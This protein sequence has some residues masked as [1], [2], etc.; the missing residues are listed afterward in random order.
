MKQVMFFAHDAG[1]ANAIAPLIPSFNNPYVFGKGPAL[2]ILPRVQEMP[3]DAIQSIEPAFLITGTSGTDFSERDLWRAAEELHIPSL[4]VLDSWVNYGIRFSDYGTDMLHLFDRNCNRLPKYISVPDSHA[5]YDMI[6]DGVP[7][8]RIYVFGNPYFEFLASLSKSVR[9]TQNDKKILFA[10]QQFEDIYYKDSEII[11]LDALVQLIE[12]Y[13]DITILI[14]KHPNEPVNK[15]EQ[16]LDKRVMI[17]NNESVFESIH[18]S[19]VVV[20]VNS[21]VLI[22]AMF[23]SKKIISYQPKSKNGKDDFILTRN[24]TLPFINNQY[25]FE[26][27]FHKVFNAKKS[28]LTR[29][30]PCE[31]ITSAIS[32]FIKE[33]IYVET[34]N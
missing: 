11:V 18:I 22:E 25:D 16:Y 33:I 7:E 8:N 5:K 3:E 21:M 10:S 15:F 30:I 2:K 26:Q 28:S 6:N 12:K 34:R 23:F 14:R 9:N 24:N 29:S 27:Y 4:A 19:E 31:G 13:K 32:D 1:G 20:S 17:D